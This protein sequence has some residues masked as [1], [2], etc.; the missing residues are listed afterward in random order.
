MCDSYKY[1]CFWNYFKT[2]CD[3]TLLSGIVLLIL[4]KSLD[5]APAIGQLGKKLQN[6]LELVVSSLHP[7]YKDHWDRISE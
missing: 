4:R 5:K 6:Q 1:I 2:L 7:V 3:I